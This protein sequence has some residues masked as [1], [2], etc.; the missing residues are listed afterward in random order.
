M[1]RA[2]FGWISEL[3]FNLAGISYRK[4]LLVNE[5]KLY[6]VSARLPDLHPYFFKIL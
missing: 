2:Y 5:Q 3:G 4:T 1:E 6:L